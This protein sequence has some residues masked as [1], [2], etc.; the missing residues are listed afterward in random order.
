MNRN[1]I[2]SVYYN[3]HGIILSGGQLFN[4]PNNTS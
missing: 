4:S 3:N 1:L 2:D